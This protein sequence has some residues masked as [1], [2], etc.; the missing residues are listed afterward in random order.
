MGVFC[1]PFTF[2]SLYLLFKITFCE[3]SPMANR[4][5]VWATIIDFS[6]LAAIWVAYF[7][8]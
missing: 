7:Y 6:W 3:L 2:Y 4:K 8:I 5:F 1:L